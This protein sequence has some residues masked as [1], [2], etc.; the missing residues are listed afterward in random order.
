MKA[1]ASNGFAV[2]GD[3]G[4]GLVSND[5]CECCDGQI[6]LRADLCNQ[7]D[8]PPE[9]PRIIT[10]RKGF[11]CLDGCPVTG[12]RI[13]SF[14]GY[15]YTV[16]SG[17][18]NIDCQGSRSAPIE[19]PAPY[20]DATIA[21]WAELLCKSLEATCLN[22][23]CIPTE[24]GCCTVPFNNS[25]GCSCPLPKRFR[26][27]HVARY[28]YVSTAYNDPGAC[29]GLGVCEDLVVDV[30]VYAD[31]ECDDG[32]V[33]PDGLAEPVCYNVGGAAVISGLNRFSSQDPPINLNRTYQVRPV[34]EQRFLGK[35][36]SGWFG[37]PFGGG[38]V[39]WIPPELE[40]EVN[41]QF[42][43]GFCGGSH[44][45]L[46][47][48][49]P[50]CVSES[51]VNTNCRTIYTRS[52]DCNFWEADETIYEDCRLYDRLMVDRGFSS[53][54]CNRDLRWSDSVTDRRTIINLANCQKVP[55]IGDV[56]GMPRPS[57]TKVPIEDEPV[58]LST[59]LGMNWRG[60]PFPKRL[61][62]FALNGTPLGTDPG[63]GCID[64]LKSLVEKPKP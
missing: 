12:G 53:P 46:E 18:G 9:I 40:G 37:H 54:P 29:A 17:S 13:I 30:D 4:T 1:V 48:E 60:T 5:P 23:A 31:Y 39:R 15:C 20:P 32:N 42:A 8:A 21:V 34:S 47:N 44:Y 27:R 11:I 28:R 55:I 57:P 64:R 61:L 24:P 3:A 49:P 38:P 22:E 52:V 56:G 43:Q 59:W 63:C 10:F 45:Y 36:S 7:G 35:L 58:Q 51:T 16:V 2:V 19:Y 50:G 62:D 41:Y 25:A 26:V 14:R 6:W 33:R